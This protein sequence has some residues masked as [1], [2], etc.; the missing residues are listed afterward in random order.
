ME[1]YSWLYV[2]IILIIEGACLVVLFYLLF[3]AN[4]SNIISALYFVKL[5]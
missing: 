5:I 4:I 1:L 3:S 2:I